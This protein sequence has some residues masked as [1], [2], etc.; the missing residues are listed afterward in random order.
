MK[1]QKTNKQPQKK[2]IQKIYNI[3]PT[4]IIFNKII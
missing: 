2:S 4:K 3:N 1:I